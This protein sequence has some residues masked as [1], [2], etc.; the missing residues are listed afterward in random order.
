MERSLESL[1]KD[2]SGDF[3]KKQR[4]FEQ[5]HSKIRESAKERQIEQS[6]LDEVKN[7]AR[8]RIELD[9]QIKNL[10]RSYDQL[11]TTLDRYEGG[12]VQL[13]EILAAGAEDKH[14]GFDSATFSLLFSETFNVSGGFLEEQCAFLGSLPPIDTLK[15]RLECYHEHNAE[16]YAEVERLK[17]KNVVLGKNYRRMVMACTGWSE[18]QVDEAAHGLTECI[19]DLNENPLPEDVAIEILMKDRGQDW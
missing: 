10:E 18:R 1:D 2:L 3:G 4:E 6:Q 5:W 12:D 16:I 8:E 13:S 15:K 17:S 9:R 7:K 19:K 14:L 11:A